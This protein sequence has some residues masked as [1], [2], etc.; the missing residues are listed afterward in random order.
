MKVAD[1]IMPDFLIVG[2]AKS[3]TTALYHYLGQHPEVFLSP[4]KE[5]NFFAQKGKKLDF[6]GPKDNL[7]THKK[8]ITETVDY[9]NQF[10]N[11]TNEKAIGEI[12]PSYLYYK[13]A[14]KNIKEHIPEVKIIAILREPVSRAF[15]A[16]VHLT[17]DGREYLSFS[18]A[19]VDEPR[20]INDNWSEIWHYIEEG[21]YYDQLKR[22]YD[23]FPK[24][25]I[26]VIIYEDFKNNPSRVYTEICDFI[27]VKNSFVPDMNTKHNTGSLSNNRFLTRLFMKPNF[28]KTLF[29]IIM[30]SFLK[31]KIEQRLFRSNLISTPTI[32]K[33]NEQRLKLLFDKD[34]RRLEELIDTKINNW[35]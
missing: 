10:T 13:D 19:I 29:K 32:S 14:P 31:K 18:D 11:V 20:R 34:L 21:K 17:R 3:G 4:I 33:E 28:I 9:Y 25:N 8:T 6:N 7:I 24:E 1:K 27:G 5:T 22:Y 15:S 35:K 2:A 23:S 12:C 30:P 26:K 16:W